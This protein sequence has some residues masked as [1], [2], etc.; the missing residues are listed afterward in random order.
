MKTYKLSG[1]ALVPIEITVPA[2]NY[3]EAERKAD[4]LESDSI[5]SAVEES[6][7]LERW[8]IEYIEEVEE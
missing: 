8:E 6:E 7:E 3:E 5:F 4:E 1:W 2:R